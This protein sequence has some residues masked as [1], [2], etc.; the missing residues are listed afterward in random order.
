MIAA[1]AVRNGQVTE[2]ALGGN[3]RLERRGKLLVGTVHGYDVALFDEGSS[4]VT[5]KRHGLKYATMRNAMKEF[6]TAFGYPA[7]VS[8]AKGGFV[9]QSMGKTYASETEE[10]V[11]NFKID[12]SCKTVNPQ[13]WAR[14]LQSQAETGKRP[15]SDPTN[16]TSTQVAAWMGL[17]AKKEAA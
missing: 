12:R 15:A 9:V 11:L 5:L 10:L 6:L 8:F 17:W 13:L 16:W 2:A 7:S 3:R 1:E 4:Q 14:F